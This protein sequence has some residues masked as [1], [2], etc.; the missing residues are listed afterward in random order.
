M[1][2]M[3]DKSLFSSR[4]LWLYVLYAI[5][6]FAVCQASALFESGGRPSTEH[7]NL[8]W[9]VGGIFML[10]SPFAF[11]IS[12]CRV[13][14]ALGEKQLRVIVPGVLVCVLAGL[15]SFALVMLLMNLGALTAI[16]K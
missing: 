3:S 15:G 10:L 13:G 4:F 7:L 11:F 16:G 8:T 12:L 6:G 1:N 9:S 5:V 2:E 14:T